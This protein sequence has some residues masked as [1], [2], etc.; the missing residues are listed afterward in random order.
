MFV[1]HI[2]QPVDRRSWKNRPSSSTRPPQGHGYFTLPGKPGDSRGGGVKETEKPFLIGIHSVPDKVKDLRVPDRPDVV[3]RRTLSRMRRLIAC[4]SQ[5]PN[6][7]TEHPEGSKVKTK[8]LWPMTLTRSY[9]SSSSSS[10]SS[11]F[12]RTTHKL[13]C[14]SI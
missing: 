11:S 10:S 4:R 3:P 9:S 14:T 12:A 6:D 2:D 1:F 5:S 13:K 8:F 7:P